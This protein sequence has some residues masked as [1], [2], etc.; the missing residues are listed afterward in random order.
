MSQRFRDCNGKS[1]YKVSG[2][3]CHTPSNLYDQKNQVDSIL[4]YMSQGLDKLRGVQGLMGDQGFQGIQGLVGGEG[5]TGV[6]G[7]QGIQ[8]IQG[9]SGSGGGGGGSSGITI[10]SLVT[11]YNNTV[12]STSLPTVDPS[13][14]V[15]NQYVDD[16]YFTMTIGFPFTLMGQTYTSVNL[17]SNNIVTFGPPVSPYNYN[18]SD[19]N[20]WVSYY[21][22]PS[23]YVG[24][25]DGSMRQ[26]YA[27]QAYGDDAPGVVG[28]R[29]CTIKY[30]GTQQYSQSN[31]P[32]IIW[33]LT[34]KENQPNKLFLK[35]L[36]FNDNGKTNG[37]NIYS[38]ASTGRLN[39]PDTYTAFDPNTQTELEIT[40]DK[41]TLST[42]Y[43]ASKLSFVDKINSIVVNNQV[44]AVEVDLGYI[45]SD[46]SDTPS[47]NRVNNVISMTQ[48]T[49]DALAT[50]DPNTLYVITT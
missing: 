9:P 41:Q 6:D 24:A 15:Q 8:G 2:S 48:A 17:Y 49:Y 14:L 36:S 20:T 5:P 27:T 23:F 21:P 29:E 35:I 43:T 22:S 39:V 4:E 45:L 10:S 47:S 40:L 38:F 16:G 25:G 1:I 42:D 19:Y 13:V 11:N 30:I 3:N 34:L 12:T 18:Y 50:Y 44:D 32:D 33:E 28:Q 31:P 7:F 26:V 46:T 37:V